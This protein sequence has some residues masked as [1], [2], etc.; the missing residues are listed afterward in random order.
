MADDRYYLRARANI[1]VQAI[2][3]ADGESTP[4]LIMHRHRIY[5]VFSSRKIGE[6]RGFRNSLIEIYRV[7]INGRYT[8]V[9]CEDGTWFVREKKYVDEMRA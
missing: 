3:S 7:R 8:E 4:I 5:H 1:E 9:Y 6:K 2:H